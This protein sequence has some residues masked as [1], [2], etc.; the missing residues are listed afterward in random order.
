MQLFFGVQGQVVVDDSQE[1]REVDEREL[2]S[3]FEWRKF[4]FQVYE[5]LT[6][7]L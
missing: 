4:S 3:H 7:D 2:C 1:G 5:R 6:I